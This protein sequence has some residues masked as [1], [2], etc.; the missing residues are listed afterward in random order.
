MDR[1]PTGD[2]PSVSESVLVQYSIALIGSSM[3]PPVR[4][5][6]E[7]IVYYERA[8]E[9]FYANR[10]KNPM[11]AISGIMLFYWW[12]A[13]PPDVVSMDTVWWWT[14]VAIRQA[15]QMGMHREPAPGQEGEDTSLRRRIWWTL[16]VGF[17]SWASH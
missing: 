10:E 11:H 1:G 8:K 4:Q 12:G 17:P 3:E 16:F 14:G 6:V 2:V 7:P 15:Q 13:S 5:H 9:L